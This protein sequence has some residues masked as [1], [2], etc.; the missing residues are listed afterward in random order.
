MQTNELKELSLLKG[1]EHF[2]EGCERFK[3]DAEQ[4]MPLKSC[5]HN[6]LNICG[7]LNV[8]SISE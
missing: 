5:I 1:V 7:V 8:D 4:E 3:D 2:S 6:K